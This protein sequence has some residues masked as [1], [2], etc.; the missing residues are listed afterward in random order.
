VFPE[1]NNKYSFVNTLSIINESR[2]IIMNKIFKEQN[3]LYYKYIRKISC[4]DGFSVL[5]DRDGV[6]YSMGKAQKGQLGYDLLYD[7]SSIISGIKCQITPKI[8]ESLC[9]KKVVVTDIICGSDF[10]FAIDDTNH[11]Y[12]WGNNDHNQIAR[13]TELICDS[14]P[15]VAD[16]LL[17]YEK[18]TK[19]CCGWMHGS[20]LTDKGE[21]FIWGNPYYDYNSRLPNI[22]EPEKINFNFRVVDLACGFHHFCAILL[23]DDNYE[24]YTW[25][26]NDYGQCGHPIKEKLSLI[27]MKIN[28]EEEKIMEIICGSFHTICHL[29]KDKIIGFGHNLYFKFNI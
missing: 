21:V 6:L 26:A 8:I 20:C 12:S 25:G 14:I 27:P 17:P 24:L 15:D 9:N 23:E 3:P 29:N 28:F 16:Y 4:G 18:I 7:E 11:I 22:R 13:K 1:E 2:G 10:S 5:L 19:I